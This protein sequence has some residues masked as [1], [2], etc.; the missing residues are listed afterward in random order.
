MLGP[1]RIGATVQ[2]KVSARCTHRTLAPSHKSL[3]HLPLVPRAYSF[4]SRV[5]CR[6]S[7][8]SILSA[9]IRFSRAFSFKELFHPLG[10]VDINHPKLTLPAVEGL[11]AD[12]ILP[13]HFLDR[14]TPLCLPQYTYLLFGRLFFA[15]HCLSPF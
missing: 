10:L 11:F 14:F 13:A 6:I 1:I 3:C 2:V 8:P 12:V 4:F 15:F 9:S 7:I 5:S